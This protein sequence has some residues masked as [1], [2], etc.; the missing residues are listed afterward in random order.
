MDAH[1]TERRQILG[2]GQE[3]VRRAAGS[4]A[5][6][7]SLH[8]DHSR[9]FGYVIVAPYYR[10]ASGSGRGSEPELFTPGLFLSEDGQWFDI[11]DRDGETGERIND[12]PPQMFLWRVARYFPTGVKPQPVPERIAT[13]LAEMLRDYSKGRPY[14]NEAGE[15]GG[16]GSLTPREREVLALM[17]EGRTNNAIA[18]ELVVTSG[19]REARVEHLRKAQPAGVQRRPPPRARRARVP[20]RGELRAFGRSAHACHAQVALTQSARTI[21]AW[22]SRRQPSG[23]DPMTFIPS[24]I[25]RTAVQ[26]PACRRSRTS[27]V[28]ASAVAGRRS[29]NVQRRRP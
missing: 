15:A 19:A 4:P 25:Q 29:E 23:R 13:R 26:P 16:L 28:I 3:F 17:A 11:P 8:A 5:S 1:A 10:P 6:R 22:R 14:T 18:R 21:A 12:E 27:P 2:L 9:V 20:A 7:S 24:T